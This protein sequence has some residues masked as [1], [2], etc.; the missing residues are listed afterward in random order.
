MFKQL[1]LS[2]LLLCASLHAQVA[3]VN[4]ASFR[5]DQPVAPGSWA[6]AFG[7][8][9]GVATTTASSFPLPKTLGGVK[10][11]IGGID[12][13]IYDVRSTQLTFLIPY[14]ALPDCSRSL[15]PLEPLR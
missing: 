13:A 2:L 9:A 14:G 1:G 8:F 3:I 12:S 10:V 7:N 15:S 6:A 11:T 5:G 4:N